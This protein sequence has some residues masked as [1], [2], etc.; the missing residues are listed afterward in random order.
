[1]GEDRLA[2][3]DEGRARLADRATEVAVLLMNLLSFGEELLSERGA[4]GGGRRI[5]HPLHP[6]DHRREVH[7]GRARLADLRHLA[8]ETTAHLVEVGE[9]SRGE[10]DRVGPGDAERRRAAHRETDDRIDHLRGVGDLDLL[11]PLGE[12][13][14][15]DQD[16]VPIDGP[17][18]LQRFGVLNRGGS[19]GT[20]GTLRSGRSWN[21]EGG[22]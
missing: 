18:P 10:T 22:V 20:H 13:G 6:V 17:G 2:I 19:L 8:R 5:D 9:L 21:G 14:L 7:R 11:L 16:D 1:M 3:F 12:E 15:F 4:G